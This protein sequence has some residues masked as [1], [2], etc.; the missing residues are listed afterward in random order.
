[1]RR[2]RHDGHYYGAQRVARAAQVVHQHGVT[3][4]RD[5]AVEV[6]VVELEHQRVAALH[7][8]AHVKKR[9]AAHLHRRDYATAAFQLLLAARQRERKRCCESKDSNC[10]SSHLYTLF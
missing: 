8:H 6:R 2:A 9:V 10:H 7:G 3:V 5:A 4:H 1:M